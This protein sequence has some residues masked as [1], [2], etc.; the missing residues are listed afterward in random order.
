MRTTTTYTP[1]R[2]IMLIVAV[3]L[4]LLA[5]FGIGNIGTVSTVDLGLA[6]FAGAFLVPGVAVAP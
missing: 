1:V 2:W 4:F 5:T 3:L 6:F